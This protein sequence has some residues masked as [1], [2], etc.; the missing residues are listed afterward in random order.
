MHTSKGCEQESGLSLLFNLCEPG[1]NSDFFFLRPPTTRTMC[2][3]GGGVGFVIEKVVF[4]KVS[5]SD[6]G[7]HGQNT[8][9]R[10]QGFCPSL[11]HYGDR[12]L[13]QELCFQQNSVYISSLW[14]FRPNATVSRIGL[15]ESRLRRRCRGGPPSPHVMD[16]W[17][18]R[19]LR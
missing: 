10:V 17:G 12:K 7:S 8:S 4:L 3:C 13:G 11:L 5:V 1:L 16:D 15:L 6:C 14:V 9:S 18:A 2:M 19:P